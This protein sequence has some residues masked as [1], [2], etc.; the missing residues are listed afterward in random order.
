M[1]LRVG[2][3]PG[4]Q[5]LFLFRHLADVPGVEWHTGSPEALLA[6]MSRGELDISGGG[7][8]PLLRALA[9]GSELIW[10]AG[11][12]PRPAFAALL[13]PVDSPI[14]SLEDLPG[15][16]VLIAAGSWHLRFLAL[17]MTSIGARLAD[18]QLLEGKGGMTRV[19]AAQA[20]A[21]VASGAGLVA[22][23]AEG[24]W[25]EVRLPHAQL[26]KAG[27]LGNR[28]LVYG[29]RQLLDERRAELQGFLRQLREHS[30]WVSQN[31]AQASAC[32]AHAHPG[33]EPPA[34][35]QQA[36]QALPWALE[37]ITPAHGREMQM[38]IDVL[39][40]DGVLPRPLDIAT[41]LADPALIF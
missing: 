26:A 21:W 1:T 30:H 14:V 3:H 8:V 37:P 29:R 13:T 34:L 10:L 41:C 38:A 33:G 28:S 27:W 2:I 15:R 9:S 7:C 32:L 6:A 17:A 39:A 36:L 22:A 4:N 20:D 18:L 16:R 5:S 24:C 25:R 12:P 35:W 11:S 31:L 23:R 19:Q 40:R